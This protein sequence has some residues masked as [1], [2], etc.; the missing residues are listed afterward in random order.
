MKKIIITIDGYSSCGKSTLAKQVA[1]QLNYVFVD[2][3]AMYRAVTYYFIKNNLNWELAEDVTNAL[4]KISLAFEYNYENGTSD[5]LLNG[6]N[7]EN[8]IREMYVNDKVSEVAVIKEIRE[9]TV[10]EQQ[11]NSVSKGIVMDG[12]DIGT[13][14]FPNAELKIFLTADPEERVERRYNQ[15]LHLGKSVDREE[16]KKNLEKRD[17]ID[18]HRE[19]SPLK[20]ADD[21]ITLDNTDLTTTEQL[22]IVLGW[23]NEKINN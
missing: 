20:K 14:V 5:I 9:F 3:G 16:I 13:V 1:K 7:V 11:K 21:A 15:L 8:E 4:G 18:T 22:E 17:Y 6:E 12:R 23:A 19:V 2:S 10:A